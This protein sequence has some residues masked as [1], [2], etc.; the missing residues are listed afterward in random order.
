[1]ESLSVDLLSHLDGC[2]V[3]TLVPLTGMSGGKGFEKLDDL[4]S[5]TLVGLGVLRCLERARPTT[6]QALLSDT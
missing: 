3:G 5:R 1:M 4:F 2:P 6:L